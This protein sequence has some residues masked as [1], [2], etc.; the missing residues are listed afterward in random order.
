MENG[1]EINLVPAVHNKGDLLV[2]SKAPD[3]HF[4]FTSGAKKKKKLEKNFKIL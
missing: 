3:Y 1:W 4:I 2:R